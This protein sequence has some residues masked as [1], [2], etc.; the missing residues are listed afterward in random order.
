MAGTHSRFRGRAT[1]ISVLTD[2]TCPL[3]PVGKYRPQVG[4]RVRARLEVSFT[5]AESADRCPIRSLP[6]VLLHWLRTRK[7]VRWYVA[8]P[9]SES[10]SHESLVSLRGTCVWFHDSSSGHCFWMKHIRRAEQGCVTPFSEAAKRA[11]LRPMTAGQARPASHPSPAGSECSA[12][13][14]ELLNSPCG[15]PVTFKGRPIG[16][17]D[18]LIT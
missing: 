7:C 5:S 10:P 8:T 2:A 18:L 3:N 9:I 4:A 11:I 12:A 17:G 14:R 13:G 6:R 1:E 15:S 16:G